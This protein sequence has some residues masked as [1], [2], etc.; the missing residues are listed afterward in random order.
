M[1]ELIIVLSVSFIAIVLAIISRYRTVGTEEAVVITGSM[2]GSRNVITTRTGSKVKIIKG[3]GYFL[4]PV[5]QKAQK[6]SLQTLMLDVRVRD[7]Y[8]STKIRVSV[9]GTVVVKVGGVNESIV[10][11]AEQ[12]M[13]QPKEIQVQSRE[14]AEGHLRSIVSSMTPEAI[15][16]DREEFKRNV[17]EVVTTDLMKLGLEVLSFNIKEITDSDDYFISLGRI[18]SAEVKKEAA[19]AV[20]ENES[21]T[22]IM[23]AQR[24]EEARKAE[25]QKEIHIAE[26]DKDR[27]LKVAEYKMQQDRAKAEADQAYRLQEAITE[28]KIVEERMKAQ[29]IQREKEIELENKEVQRKQQEYMAE[30]VEK[31]TAERQAREE[32]AKAQ[33]VEQNAQTDAHA[34]KI[35]Q[36]A[37]VRATEKILEAEAQA[38]SEREIGLAE[39]DVTLAQGKASAQALEL[40]K[41]AEA[42]GIRETGLAEAEAREQLALA[43]EKLGQAGIIDLALKTLPAVAKEVSAPMAAIQNLSIIDTGDGKGIGT[44]SKSVIDNIN[45]VS[46]G[47]K[48]TTGIDLVELMGKMADKQNS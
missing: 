22:R 12:F 32:L 21:A 4:F 8:T 30:I 42:K 33:L 45:V 9:D 44:L 43:L 41:L 40:N 17:Q 10:T 5:I 6:L 15:N 2:L 7:V 14:I 27:D 48:S 25:I 16:A 31:A 36:E 3:G 24:E 46:Q 29:I 34:Y 26:Y 23:K 35:E 19:I 20:A 1:L 18:R 11:A 47:L 37:K 39:A 28:Q 38:K 13:G